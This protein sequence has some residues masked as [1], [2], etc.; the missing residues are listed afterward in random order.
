MPDSERAPRVPE[1]PPP[2]VREPFEDP[3]PAPKPPVSPSSGSTSGIPSPVIGSPIRMGRPPSFSLPPRPAPTP[4]GPSQSRLPPP[5]PP[6]PPADTGRTLKSGQ[7]NAPL[8][9]LAE[10][11]REATPEPP[12][13]ELSWKS[14]FE[15]DTEESDA[16]LSDAEDVSLRSRIARTVFPK[17]HRKQNSSTS[18]AGQGP[19]SPNRLRKTPSPQQDQRRRKSGRS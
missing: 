4:P 12:E 15:S 9:S 2:R 3:R 16:E 7:L 8:P 11:S 10:A 5:P 6:P 18:S 14:K 19:S 1:S 13:P 17:G